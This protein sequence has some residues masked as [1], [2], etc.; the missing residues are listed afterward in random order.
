MRRAL[1]C[2]VML[3]PLIYVLSIIPC[4]VTRHYITIYR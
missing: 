2:A 4:N 3:L 1:L